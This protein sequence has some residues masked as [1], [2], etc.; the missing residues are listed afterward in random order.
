VRQRV[1]AKRHARLV[2]YRMHDGRNA[3]TFLHL[4][5]GSAGSIPQHTK[6]LSRVTDPLRRQTAPPGVII[7]EPDPPDGDW[8]GEPALAQVQ[9]F[10]T[11]FPLQ[12]CRE[13]NEFFI[14]TFGSLECCL[15][16]GA[17]SAQVYALAEDQQRAI[18]PSLKAGDFVVLEEVKGP[19]TGH[20]ADADAA[21]RQ[22]VQLVAVEEATDPVYGDELLDGQLQIAAPGGTTLPLLHITWRQQDALAFPLC[23]SARPPGKNPIVHISVARGNMVLVDHG[24]TIL[25]R[26][27]LPAPVPPDQPC[28]L[29]MGLGPMTMERQPPDVAYEWDEATGRV[30]LETPRLDLT[31]TA[32]EAQPALGVLVEFPTGPEIWTPVPHL[33]DSPPFAPH[34]V[35]D[36]DLEGRGTLRFGD[37]EYGR[38]PAG[39]T[40]FTV[41]Y[42]V[43]NGRAGNVGAEALSHLVHPP[44][45]LW[46]EILQISN[47]LPA[48][49]GT[50]PETIEEVRRLAP[51]AFH[52]EQ[53]RAVTEEDYATAARKL[54]GVAGAVATFR[55][56]GSWYTV[57][58][59]VDPLNPADLITEPGGRTRLTP[60]FA[61]RVEA[62]LTRYRLAGY[63]LE[64]RSGEYVPLEIDLEVCVN[65]GHFRGDVGEAVRQA[66]SNRINVDGTVGFFHPDNFTFGQAVYLSRLYAAVEAV[67]GVDAA[68]VTRFQRHGEMAKGELEAGVMAMG[69]WEIARLDNDPNFMENGVLRLVTRGGK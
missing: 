15:P 29:P 16:R 59:G 34:C 55:W 68:V 64:I 18:R 60:E 30:R 66:L 45:E 8:S 36:V 44:A 5:A 58:V 52:A 67:E 24:R 38:E 7:P 48:H 39:A 57:F 62:F 61:S 33:L 10:E 28:R 63:D 54:P 4:R 22:V 37:G 32:G 53:F 56:T 20:P 46:P 51:A 26:F 41:T 25:E 3:W 12:V 23:L 42:R 35:V 47:P 31:G 27:S 40:G 1:S 49:A 9:V 2:D 65:P 11:A 50:D 21:H 17:T 43:G 14:H 19:V 13:N 69:S 6:V